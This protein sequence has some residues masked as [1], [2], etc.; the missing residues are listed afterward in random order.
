MTE[1]N[2]SE[3]EAVAGGCIVVNEDGSI[4]VYLPGDIDSE[5]CS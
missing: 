3:L 2:E 5:S 4:G 1:L